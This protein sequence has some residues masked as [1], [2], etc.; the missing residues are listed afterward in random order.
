MDLND[1]NRFYEELHK[2][3]DYG[4]KFINEIKNWSL[5]ES[6]PLPDSVLKQV[7]IE[8]AKICLF[9]LM[10]DKNSSGSSLVDRVKTVKNM[11]TELEAFEAKAKLDPRMKED[12]NASQVASK[13][14]AKSKIKALEEDYDKDLI[15]F[16]REYKAFPIH[17]PRNEVLSTL[18]SM[19]ETA[20]R[21]I[22]RSY[23]LEEITGNSYK[24]DRTFL[25]GFLS[26]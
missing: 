4:G 15:S 5:S 9:S 19:K 10:T 11:H 16:E 13:A 20:N 18:K 25:E 26:H 8:K 24:D 12:L 6:N 21:L 2:S 17:L 7:V 14:W 23:E 1:S 22:A 3:G